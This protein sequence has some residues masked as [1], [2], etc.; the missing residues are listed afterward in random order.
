MR[1]KEKEGRSSGQEKGDCYVG[2][3]YENS[4]YVKGKL[5]PKI[6]F[7]HPRRLRGGYSW[8]ERK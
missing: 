1:R 2:Q 4:T 7:A 5:Q 8:G 3:W 6:V